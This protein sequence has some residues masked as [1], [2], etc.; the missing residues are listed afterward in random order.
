MRALIQTIRQAIARFRLPDAVRTRYGIIYWRQENGQYQSSTTARPLT[1]IPHEWEPLT[2]TDAVYYRQRGLRALTL[3][4]RAVALLQQDVAGD[5]AQ[6]PGQRG[7]TAQ[8]EVV[9]HCKDCGLRFTTTD[10]ATMGTLG[11][12]PCCT[13]TR[14]ETGLNHSGLGPLARLGVSSR[15][16]P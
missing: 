10:Q 8:A 14:V 5:S 2:Y 13:S 16:S 11:Q 4:P 7:R 3:T 15:R 6:G 1:E 12:C 9:N